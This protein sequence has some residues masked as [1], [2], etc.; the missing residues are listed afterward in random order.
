MMSF[1]EDTT[2]TVLHMARRF[3]DVVEVRFDAFNY[4]VADK[5]A[6]V[7]RESRKMQSGLFS[8][9]ML[10]VLLGLALIVVVM[11]MFG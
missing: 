4:L 7:S 3:H 8:N 10:L 9:N 1:F 5:V 6:I 11:L 2:V